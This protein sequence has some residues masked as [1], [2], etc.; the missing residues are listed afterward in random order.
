MQNYLIEKQ[1]D[2]AECSITYL[3]GGKTST[4]A[5][6]LLL[7]GWAVDLE[8]Y[9]EI[10]NLLA[11]RYQVIAPYL[12][13]FGKSTAPEYIQDY[14]DYAEVLANFIK[15]LK[16]PKVHVIGHSLGGGFAIAL[17]ALKPSLVSS[18]IV[19]D[20][21]GIPL[22]SVPEVL[23]RRSIEMPAQM[24]QMKL[25]TFLQ[26]VQCLLY[27][28]LFNP[29]RVIQ[30]AGLALEKDIRPILPHILSPCLILWGG[31]DI[32]TPIYF[33]QE[34]AQGI[35]DSKLQILPGV[36]HEWSLFYPEK[37]TGSIFDFIDELERTKTGLQTL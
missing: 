22:G 31:N 29:Q 10:L 26:I 20:S 35:K 19:A 33:A 11:R 2:L 4:A 34:F 24:G 5:P 16:L 15:V 25:Q 30:T 6:I 14:S 3:Q 17:A 7:H 37:F 9:Q 21:T 36:Y 18:L 23:L 8:P 1:V 13:G 32:L 28:S 27:N 12:P